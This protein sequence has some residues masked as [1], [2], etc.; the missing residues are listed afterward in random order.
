MTTY[1][2]TVDSE[3]FKQRIIST[4][5][6]AVAA[7]VILFARLF[8]LQLVEGERLRHLSVN[9]RI[10][11]QDIDPSRGLIFDRNGL[12]I[13]DNRPAFDIYITLKD[14]KPVEKTLEKLTY[15]AGFPITELK[16]RIRR[17]KGRGAYKPIL[18]RQDISRDILAAIEVHKFDL[19]GITVNVK[20][21][22]H[23]LDRHGAA[24]LVGYLSEINAN[25][26]KSGKYSG[27]RSG[28]F[29]GKFG[30]EKAYENYLKGH[31][32]GRQVEV[33]ARGRVIRPLKTVAAQPGH[34]L[35]LTL[36]QQV[37]ARAEMMLTGKAGAAVAIEPDTGRILALASSPAFNQNAFVDGMSAGQWRT[38]NSNPDHPM[39]NKAIQGTYPPASTYK[40]ITAIAG[41]EEGVIDENTLMHC[42]GYFK[43]GNRVS[44]CWKKGGHGKVNVV[45]ALE[46][47]CDVFFYQVGLKLG[48]DRL[49]WHAKACG[50][51]TRTG[52]KFD[53]EKAGLIPTAAWK[54]RRFGIPWQKG[55]T[56]SV[57]IGQGYNLVTPLQMAVVTAAIAN[58]GT[59]YRP[60]IVDRIETAAG[61][62]VYANT[63]E[64]AGQLS[65][66]SATL[67]LIREGLFKVVQGE[68]GTARRIRTKGIDISGKTGTAQV[69]A[70]KSEEEQTETIV[71]DRHKDHAWFV[72]YAPSESPRIAVAVIVEHGEH[73][74]SA[75]APIAKEMILAFLTGKENN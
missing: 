74:S 27:T 47:S 46:Q 68:A 67:A 9:N 44:R 36:D 25:E 23:Y 1:L 15:Y 45:M 4:V 35:I 12:R 33:D 37:Q 31:H 34:N 61:E 2:N 20:P 40:I 11:L 21:R 26:L 66:N 59:R 16:E 51:G 57:A 65:M 28:D 22:R 70:L 41:L 49:A 48:I 8:Y 62:Q 5:L 6:I 29:I 75:A 13:A 72:A 19:P 50:L 39:V 18:I 69:V 14:A 7:F 71:Q 53:R 32:G 30:V 64:I 60:A 24:H 38:L 52:I 43:V 17:R 55:E 42:P 63:I 54:K 58:G 56:L 73:G 3:W 10:R